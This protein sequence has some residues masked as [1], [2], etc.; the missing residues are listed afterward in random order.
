M[1][2]PAVIL[3][4]TGLL[5]VAACVLFGIGAGQILESTQ[6]SIDETDAYLDRFSPGYRDRRDALPVGPTKR[7]GD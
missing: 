3:I 6:A 5:V 4:V 2:V 7:P 1:L